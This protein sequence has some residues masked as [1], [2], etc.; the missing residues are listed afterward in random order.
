M[1]KTIRNDYCIKQFTAFNDELRPWAN[2][3]NLSKD[4]LYAS[5]SHIVGKIKANLCMHE[6]T[7]NEKDP[8]FESVLNE[9]ISHEI[10]NYNV[11]DLFY[12]LMKMD[13]CYVPEM[14]DCDDC[15]G[16]GEQ[17]CDHCNSEYECTKCD[18]SGK[19]ES[20]EL[21]ASGQYDV[22]LNKYKFKR[23]YIDRI[24]KTAII[25]EQKIIKVTF[26]KEYKSVIFYVG[27]FTI[28]LMPK[29]IND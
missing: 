5:D 12:S 14:V 8:N 9:H 17:T 27:D 4:Y 24:I 19:M 10:I 16:Y 1:K 29:M 21:T 2:K 13:V 23:D 11:D 22:Y 3:V 26:Q 6:Y 20:K 18:G 7:G 15:D 25:L 28:L